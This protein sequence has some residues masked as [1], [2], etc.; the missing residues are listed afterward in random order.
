MEDPYLKPCIVLVYNEPLTVT[1][2]VTV[3]THNAA[4]R[5]APRPLRAHSTIVCLTVVVE[6][7]RMG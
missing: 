5:S 4:P 1:I 6:V 2:T 3:T 7:E